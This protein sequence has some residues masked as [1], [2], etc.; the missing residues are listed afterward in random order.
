[1]EFLKYLEK[2]LIQRKKELPNGSYTSRLFQ[3]GEDSILK[4]VIEESGEVLLAFK[5]NKKEEM[6]HEAA[7]LIFHL[8]VALVEKNIYLEDVVQELEKRHKK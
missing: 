7:D 6:I 8:M 3:E 2:I 5:N 1:M 4:K